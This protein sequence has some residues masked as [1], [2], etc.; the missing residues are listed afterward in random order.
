MGLEEVVISAKA[1]T[2]SETAM[3]SIQKKSANVVDGLS[4]QQLKKAG[5]SDAAGALKRVSGIN[6]EGGKYVFVRG[7]SDRYSKTT[8]NTADIPGLDPNRNTVQ[9]DIF[10]TNLIENIIVYKSYSPNLPADF[11]GGLIDIV[12]LDFPESFTLSFSVKAGINTQASLNNNFLSYEGSATDIFEYDNGYRNIP[13]D[14]S[15]DI[16]VYPEQKQNLT[17]ITSSFNKTM[18]PTALP[19]SINTRHLPQTPSP[20]HEALI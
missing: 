11:T 7:L 13:T 17:N 1:V 15:V 19:S 14:A 16:P 6:V 12:T 20:P 2:R 4:F 3:L 9:M 18:A 8:L 10:P 5:D